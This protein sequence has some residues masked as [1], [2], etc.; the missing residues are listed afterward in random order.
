MVLLK[1][2]DSLGI[3]TWT[4]PYL[5]GLFHILDWDQKNLLLKY[6][7]LKE[8]FEEHEYKER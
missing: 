5:W 6:G 1:S 2:L 8:E 7:I 4:S 3:H